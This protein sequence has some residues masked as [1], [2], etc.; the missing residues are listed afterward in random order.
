MERGCALLSAADT[1]TSCVCDDSHYNATRVA[2]LSG[3]T[4]CVFGIFW[5]GFVFTRL[6]A[7]PFQNW[8]AHVQSLTHFGAVAC[9]HPDYVRI[10]RV[11][12]NHFR[13]CVPRFWCAPEGAEFHRQGF[14]AIERA[15]VNDACQE[16]ASK[17]LGEACTAIDVNNTGMPRLLKGFGVS[18]CAAW[19]S[20]F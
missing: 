8:C 12:K 14:D 16:V 2:F 7:A 13:H 4:M 17:D 15:T 9:A 20:H 1:H 19:G 11:R 5:G 3:L 10:P 18:Q 6:A